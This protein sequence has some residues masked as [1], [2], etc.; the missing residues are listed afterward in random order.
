MKKF[1]ILMLLLTGLTG[2]AF[3]PPVIQTPTPITTCQ[4]Y[5]VDLTT[6]NPEILGALNP[7]LYTVSFHTSQAD[8]DAN[9]NALTAPSAFWVNFSQQVFVR[10]ED[11]ANPTDFSTTNFWIY[12]NAVTTGS[13]V[14]SSG[15]Q[16]GDAS[17]T[18]TVTNP[19]GLT[20]FL[21]SVNG[22]AQ[23]YITTSDAS[24]YSVD[25]SITGATNVFDIVLL[26][27]YSPGGIFCSQLGATSVHIETLPAP[28]TGSPVD[29]SIEQIPYVG[30]AVFDLTIN[31]AILMGGN[32]N[33]TVSYFPTLADAQA[34]T[35]PIVTPTAW[36][37][38]NGDTIGVRVTD[39]TSGCDA[40]R[41]FRLF[42]TNPDIVFIPDAFLKQRLVVAGTTADASNVAQDLA[43]NY[44]I[45]DSNGDGEIQYSEAANISLLNAGQGN[46][47]EMTGLEA[48]INMQY[49]N[50]GYN[51]GLASVNLSTMPLLQTLS[52]SHCALT[53]LNFANNHQLT[54]VSCEYNQIVALDMSPA[55]LVTFLRC[56]NN[57]LT[58]LNLTGLTVL[59][60]MWASNNHIGS[61]NTADLHSVTTFNIGSNNLTS[62]SLTGMN[63]LQQLTC[64]ENHIN[65][66]DTADCPNLV[67]LQCG[68]NQMATL[69]VS[70]SPLLNNLDVSNN[71]YDV[72]DLSN[73][74]SLCNFNCYGVSPLTWLNIKNGVDSCYTNFNLFYI[75]NTA[76]QFICCDDN[77]VAYFK[78]YFL[79]NQGLNVNVNSYCTIEPGGDYNTISCSSQLDANGNGC[80]AGDESFPNVRFNINDGTNSGAAFSGSNGVAQFFT[81]AGNFTITP[82]IENPSWFTISPPT[83]TVPFANT[84]NNTATPNFC[85]VPN[86]VHPDLEIVVA[87][88]TTA[89]PGFNAYY[90][91]VIRNKGNQVMSQLNGI[92]LAYNASKLDFVTATDTPSSV[93]TGTLSWD[94]ANLSPFESKS[95][96][97][98]MHVHTPTD[99]SPTVNGDILTFTATANPIAGDELPSDN[100]FNLNQTVV[101]SFDP[102]E[103]VC[104]EGNIVSPVEIGNYLH[105]TINFE[106]TGTADAENIVVRELIDTTQFDVNSLQLL[107]SSASVTTRLIG[108]VAEF[109]F[110]SINLHSGGHGNILIKI[111]SNSALVTGDMV[112]KKANI[113]FDYNFPV[114]TAPENTVF[115]SLSNP[116]VEVD[117]TISVFPNPTKGNININCGNTIKSVQLYDVQGRVLQTNLINEKQAT[118][119]MS[120]QSAGVYFIKVISDNGMAVKK[121]VKE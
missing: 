23:Q 21:Y 28:A 81:Q 120:T 43:H 9:V 66:L 118:I 27:I 12:M 34:G 59:D 35:N 62:L 80:D 103:I 37:G 46:I 111:R 33:L 95:I 112:S 78:N 116:D 19:V 102:N 39:G 8:A 55:P 3:S 26:A 85:I 67:N 114:E 69:D 41:S 121:V 52:A 64:M 58:S 100:T 106:N 110:P 90:H 63:S 45:I 2:V 30:T 20:T 44:T 98:Q 88:T 94:F 104:L 96:Y 22:G 29:L 115:Q 108:N 93:G 48:F 70:Q 18:F 60:D 38:N 49:L 7:S 75:N 1:Y 36:T 73:N 101:G 76:T 13:I 84:N 79:T 40:I 107:S 87:P 68:S 97:V 25:V 117:A 61:V 119:D 24:P 31:D 47:N 14:T 113:Y 53:G 17:F 6:K 82:S 4:D 83:A 16:C 74:P 99:P 54:Q 15:T 77:E 5:V 42:I 105:Y 71:S 11:N 32:P 72:L 51:Y 91:V 57:Q 56:Q 109:I 92:G 86:G 50:I 65:S 10:V 89:R